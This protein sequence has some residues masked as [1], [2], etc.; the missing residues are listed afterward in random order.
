MKRYRV[1]LIIGSLVLIGI[2]G[3]KA[4]AQQFAQYSQFMLN[5]YAT[6]AAYGGMD[7]SLSLTTGLRTQ[8]NEFPGAPKTQFVNVHLPL[9]FLQGS[10][11]VSLENEQLGPFKKTNISASYNYVFES[12]LGLI[13]GGF[14]VGAHQIQINGNELRTPGGAYVDQT[15]NHNDPLLS[16]GQLT[17][18]APTWGI[19]IYFVNDMIQGGLSMD[20]VPSNS[21]TAGSTQYKSSQ[22]WSLILSS[23]VYLNEL[24]MLRP[25]LLLKSDF[26]QT[27]TDLGAL[28]YYRDF[29][30]GST[31]RGYNS[32]SFDSINFIGGVQ[33]NEH[34]RLS[35][36]YDFGINR[37]RQ[38]HDG[39]H[40]FIVNYNLNKKIKTGE[41]PRIIYNPRYN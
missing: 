15:I 31:I 25:V 33:V 39:T 28:I 22:L 16:S 29:F 18:I 12:S 10:V 38:F 5:K 2:F 21:F 9:Y 20:N 35:Y 27:Q 34:F 1:F 17:G 4:E 24:I 32:N 13:S 14:K 26:V 8:W 41:L 23:D 37:I 36:S 3:P 6:N 7:R 11:G 40:E 30:G 19:G